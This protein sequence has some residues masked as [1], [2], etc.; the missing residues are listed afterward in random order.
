MGAN[1]AAKRTAVVL[2][3]VVSAQRHGSAAAMI[4][5]V[6]TTGIRLQSAKP[7]ELAVGN[8]VRRVLHFIRE[9]AQQESMEAQLEKNDT[10]QIDKQKIAGLLSRALK[11]TFSQRNFSLTNLLDRDLIEATTAD[12]A[13]AQVAAAAAGGPGLGGAAAGNTTSEFGADSET[14]DN[15]SA[16]R[17]LA[18]SAARRGRGGQWDRKNTVIEQI[19]ELIEGLEGVP[20]EIAERAIDYI[21]ANEVILTQGHSRTAFLF[22]KRAAEKRDFQVVVAEGAPSFYGVAMA[23]QLAEAGVHATAITDSAIF[24]MMARVNKVVVTADSLLANGGVLAPAG[25][26]GVAL[27]ARRHAVP[28]VVLVGLH[29]LSPL[30]SSDPTAQLNELRSPAQVVGYDITA[31][32]LAA[33]GEDYGN[34]HVDVVN[35]SLD[36]VPPELI[37]LLVTDTG[38]CTPAYIYRLLTEYYSREDNVLS[39]SILG[40]LVR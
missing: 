8:I 11:Q 38:A 28:F 6:K 3:L 37:S 18:A 40:S 22:F 36:Y 9:E 33:G 19:N 24:A 31:Q 20:E 23:R 15:A 7:N 13:M 14:G 25:T 4:E 16:R 27:A 10:S 12:G 29:K 26:H 1:Q 17:S 32:P 5:D 34:T 2:R 21:H 39:S 35:P 30:F